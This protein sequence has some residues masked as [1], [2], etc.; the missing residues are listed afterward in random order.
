MFSHKKGLYIIIQRG[1]GCQLFPPHD[2]AYIEIE[3]I[4]K[5]ENDFT[6]FIFSENYFI[7][8]SAVLFFG[9]TARIYPVFFPYVR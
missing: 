2:A 7:K 4:E 5:K 6:E 9:E 3:K 8:P 1:A